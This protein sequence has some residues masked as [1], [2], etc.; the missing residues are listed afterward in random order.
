ML[1]WLQLV[2]VGA[3]CPLAA[4]IVV[5]AIHQMRSEQ[6][7]RRRYYPRIRVSPDGADSTAQRRSIDPT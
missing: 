4:V 5:F 1:A 6:R 7:E 3:S 2:V